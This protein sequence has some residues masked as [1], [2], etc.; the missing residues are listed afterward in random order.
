YI[1]STLKEEYKNKIREGFVA[2][3]SYMDTIYPSVSH[4]SLVEYIKFVGRIRKDRIKCPFLIDDNCTIYPVRPIICRTYFVE[5]NPDEC[6]NNTDRTGDSKGDKVC[7]D[8]G[9]KLTRL[10]GYKEI[11]PLT[12]ALSEC[13]KVQEHIKIGIE[14]IVHPYR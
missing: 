12:Y 1:D 3:F 6:K 8:S 7:V 4:I 2:W 9:N 11:R 14:N 10:M 13:F 5:S